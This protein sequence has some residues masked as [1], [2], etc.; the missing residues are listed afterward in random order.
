ML[1][2][3]E[4]GYAATG[5]PKRC[6]LIQLSTVEDCRKCPPP[7]RREVY[8]LNLVWTGPPPLG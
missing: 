2:A 5:S 1:V 6:V 3:S 7:K 8:I 4:E